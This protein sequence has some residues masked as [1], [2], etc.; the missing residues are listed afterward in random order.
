MIKKWLSRPDNANTI[1]AV[2]NIDARAN[3]PPES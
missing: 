3:R 1:A 2:P